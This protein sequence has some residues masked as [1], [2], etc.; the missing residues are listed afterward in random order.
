M[1]AWRIKENSISLDELE[2]EG[3]TDSCVK[4]KLL[5][6][7]AA[8]TDRLI[9]H[10]KI[11]AE[12]PIIPGRQAVGMVVETGAEVKNCVR[13]DTVS[14][15]PLKMCGQCAKCA[16]NKHADCESPL[17]F[18]LTEDGFMRDFVTVSSDAVVKLP[19]R[20]AAKDAVFMDSIDICIEAVNKSGL[21]KGQYLVICGA[22]HL[23]IVMAQVAMYYQIVPILADIDPLYLQTAEELGVYYTINSSEADTKK[24]VFMLTGGKLADAAAYMA[25]SGYPF[26]HCLDFVKTG[27]SVVICGLEKSRADLTAP[28]CSV[29]NRRLNIHGITE[30]NK[31]TLSAVNMLASKNVT[32][33][34]LIAAEIDFS[35]VGEE[36]K[37]EISPATVY[38]KTLVKM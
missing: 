3:V 27:G 2:V 38:F 11:K 36:L 31:H 15:K 26:A 33:E 32:V 10:G 9:A 29:L 13:G 34:P 4:V 20:V 30:S 35:A 17:V 28:L 24:Q 16:D 23:G 14:I 8:V 18:G 22:T 6:C 12:L 37:K 25:D 7:S 19:E 1:K 5:Y 21:D